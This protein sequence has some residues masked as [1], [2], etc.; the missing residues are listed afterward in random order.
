MMINT[1]DNM[2]KLVVELNCKP[3]DDMKLLAS[4]IT[5][6]FHSNI[7]TEPVT[8]LLDLLDFYAHDRNGDNYYHLAMGECLCT[9]QALLEHNKDK[10]QTLRLLHTV[11]N[12]GQLPIDCAKDP[13]AALD[14]IKQYFLPCDDFI[15]G[16]CTC[17]DRCHLLHFPSL[18]T[19]VAES[20][21]R[22]EEGLEALLD[23]IEDLI[24]SEGYDRNETEQTC[25]YKFPKIGQKLK[26]PE[27]YR[28]VKQYLEKRSKHFVLDANKRH[29]F[30]FNY[31]EVIKERCRKYL[32][33]SACSVYELS[34]KIHLPRSE[35]PSM[36]SVFQR[37]PDIFEVIPP[38]NG[39]D[40]MVRCRHP[41]Q[42]GIITG[43][44]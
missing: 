37:N 11:N 14:L 33:T 7:A 22:E 35:I 40:E 25:H 19:V 13:K 43:N 3:Q 31:G 2:T 4:I 44:D 39:W 10:R 32:S 26:I 18:R 28:P 20:N 8:S 6:A 36:L 16:R 23:D 17:G 41:I 1:S 24:L 30:T 5:V 15:V 12:K 38:V 29:E 34:K 21:H 27:E 42:E 9:V